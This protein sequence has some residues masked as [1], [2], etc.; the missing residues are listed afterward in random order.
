[1]SL[2]LS[3]TVVTLF[4]DLDLSVQKQLSVLSH[5]SCHANHVCWSINSFINNVFAEGGTQSRT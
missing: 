3:F 1:M 4:D 5:R 2:V